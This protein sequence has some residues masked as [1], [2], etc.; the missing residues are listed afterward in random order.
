MANSSCISEWKNKIIADL[1][2]DV[3]FLDSLGTTELEREDLVY[4]RIFP[5]Y[6]IPD[7][8]T[9]VSTYT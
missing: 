2:N 6:Y 3:H 9:T 5:Y 7:T 8:I 4:S 1:H